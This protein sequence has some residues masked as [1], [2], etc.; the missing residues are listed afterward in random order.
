MENVRS[1]NI[2]EPL[3]KCPGNCY[4]T[5]PS[6]SS[7]TTVLT[8]IIQEKDRLFSPIPL[9]VVYCHAEK[10]DAGLQTLSDIEFYR[11]FPNQED[12]DLWVAQY[13][14]QAWMLCFDDL[15]TDFFNNEL[16]YQLLSRLSHH[17]NISVFVVGHSLFGGGKFA[18]QI[19]LNFHYF[20]LTRSVRGIDSVSRFGQQ[21]L[22][23]NGGRHLLDIFLDATKV[24]EKRRLMYLFISAHPLFSQKDK[25][26]Y[27]NIFSSE[28]PLVLYTV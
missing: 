25:M 20:I 13:S 11:G 6:F 28:Q 17:N 9:H 24:T 16:G 7:K 15:Q 22:G 10:I 2:I 1:I 8:K 4:I 18:R 3:F 21:L 23:K 12:I 19:S 14:N 5:G 27:T 26:F